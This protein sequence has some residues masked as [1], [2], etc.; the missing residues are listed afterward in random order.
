MTIKSGEFY[1][2]PRGW[3]KYKKEINRLLTRGDPKYRT[4]TYVT[5]SL[6]LHDVDDHPW[7]YPLL[8]ELKKQTLKRYVVYFL[9]GQGRVARGKRGTSAKTSVWMLPEEKHE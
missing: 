7:N 4:R 6:Y 9:I 2:F 3:P 5:P 1:N 8:R